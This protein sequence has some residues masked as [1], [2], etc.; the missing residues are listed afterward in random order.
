[1]TWTAKAPLWILATTAIMGGLY[2]FADA[3]TQFALAL[4]LWLTIDGFARYVGEKL[5]FLPKAVTVPFALILVVGI[6]ACCAWVVAD[7]VGALTTHA[8]DYEARLNEL[9]A[10][11]HARLAATGPA[12]TVGEL[13]SQANPTDLV[14]AI[15]DAL[16]GLA[17]DALFIFIYLGF[18]F[19]AASTFP[20]KLDAIFKDPGARAQ[21]A[22]VFTSIRTSMER[23]L[24]VQTIAS[25]I[26]TGLTYITLEMIGLDNALLWAFIIFFLNYIPTIGS[27]VA[28]ALPTVF[29]LVQFDQLGS[30]AAVAAGV[31]V[32]QFVIG[33]F[34]QPRMTGESLNLSTLV[35]LLALAIWGT[36]WGIAGAFLAA[37]LTVMLMIVLAQFPSVRW[38]AVLLSADGK[39]EVFNTPD[40]ED[41]K[42]A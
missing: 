3:L 21:A 34:I 1:M 19:A 17:S 5:P 31:G 39:P 26:I 4:I 10:Q 15:G 8:G 38:I 33:N 40:K 24:W 2:W 27:L 25:L 37:P 41:P 22:K 42:V 11:V 16:Q 35:V 23:Y 32:W 29:A 28:V 18:L 20:G 14:S 6:G 30:V 12:P 7:N 13:L 36:I 9:L